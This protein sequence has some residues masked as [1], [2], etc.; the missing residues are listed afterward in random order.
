MIKNLPRGKKA[1]IKKMK[2]KYEE[3]DE[4]ERQIKMKLI[5]VIIHKNIS[6]K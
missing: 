6:R 4:D 2:E 1:K 5:G 3:Q